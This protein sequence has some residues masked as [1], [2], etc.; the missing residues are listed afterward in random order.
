LGWTTSVPTTT[1]VVY[2]FERNKYIYNVTDKNLTTTHS[3]TI[4]T[5]SDKQLVPG[6]T[7]Y[8]RIKALDAKN[9]LT[10]SEEQST[11]LKG[12]NIKLR[13]VDQGNHPVS[14]SVV[15]LRAEELGN[16]SQEAKTDHN[17]VASFSDVSS[18]KH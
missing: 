12:F 2:G 3:A 6:T 7:V 11:H 14:D 1:E 18:G 5:S 10:T 16:D 17:G 13:V 15:T 9:H 8:L 4:T